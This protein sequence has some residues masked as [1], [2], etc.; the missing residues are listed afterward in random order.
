[1]LL[2]SA[3]AAVAVAVMGFASV[4]LL[5]TLFVQRPGVVSAVVYVVLVA[6]PIASCVVALWV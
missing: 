6:L 5:Y 3:P 1:M 2:L 4:P